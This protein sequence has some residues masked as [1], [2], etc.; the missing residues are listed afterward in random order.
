MSDGPRFYVMQAE[1]YRSLGAGT[2]E[3]EYA[4][5]DRLSTQAVA[6]FIATPGAQRARG[7]VEADEE[8]HATS[9]PASTARS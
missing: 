8:G 3:Y 9:V 5:V 6:L 1:G 4:V 7:D 2:Y